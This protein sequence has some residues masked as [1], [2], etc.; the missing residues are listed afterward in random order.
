[1]SYYR[2]R[3]LATVVLLVV[4]F[5]VP[6]FVCIAIFIVSPELRP[7]IG[8][9]GSAFVVYFAVVAGLMVKSNRVAEAVRRSAG[10]DAVVFGAVNHAGA[11]VNFGEFALA[12]SRMARGL[13]L[14]V[15]ADGSGIDYLAP[16]KLPTPFVH[17]PW[18]RIRSVDE[19]GGELAVSLD[20]GEVQYIV[21]G[22]R[23]PMGRRRVR[24]LAAEMAKL[25][26]N[27]GSV[28]ADIDAN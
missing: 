10:A 20:D 8:F 12:D 2:R 19:V 16:G 24:A 7:S 14:V 9:A 4:S 27:Q 11:L 17:V 15:R 13:S 21:P 26:E 5:V 25:L 3:F 6:V 23:S 18:S 28:R 1:V 22:A